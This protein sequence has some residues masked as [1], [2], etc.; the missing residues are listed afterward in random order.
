TSYEVYQAFKKHPLFLSYLQQFSPLDYY[1]KSNIASR[2][3]NRCGAGGLKFEDLRAV[4]FVG[5]WSQLKQNVP[6]YFGVGT[7]L[8]QMKDEGHWEEVKALFRNVLFFR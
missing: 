5:S 8:Q 4:P 1:S 3:S 2:P 6:G 7:A